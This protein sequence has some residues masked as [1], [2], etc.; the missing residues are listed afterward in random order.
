MSRAS[1]R[2]TSTPTKRWERHAMRQAFNHRNHTRQDRD[3]LK[4]NRFIEAHVDH[5][6]PEE[7]SPRK[8]TA[9]QQGQILIPLPFF[10]PSRITR[11]VTHLVTAAELR[12]EIGLLPLK[13]ICRSS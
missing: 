7:S 1:E 8:S 10:D 3:I 6:Y 13:S 12:I 5:Q 9:T 4:I 11:M 2:L